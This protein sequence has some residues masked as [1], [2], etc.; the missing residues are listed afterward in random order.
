MLLSVFAVVLSI[1]VAGPA[2]AGTVI[3]SDVS[4]PNVAGNSVVYYIEPDRV[5][6]EYPGHIVIFRADQD[7]EYMLAPAEKKFRRMTPETMKQSAAAA[8]KMF[9]LLR[10]MP[11]EQRAQF[12]KRMPPEQRAQFERIMTPERLAQA[13]K[14]MAGQAPKSE[15]HKTGGT[16]SFGKWTCER[17]E[18]VRN[19]QP[20]SSLCVAH[21]SDL[22]LTEE[23]LGGLQRA[24]TFIGQMAGGVADPM[25]GFRAIEKVVG[26]AA[27]P[28]HMEIPGVEMQTTVKTVEKKPLDAGLFEVPADYREE[29]MSAPR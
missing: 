13:E 16:A 29:P 4:A 14:M 20:H 18:A 19:G 7:T 17:V 21:I 1:G 27:Y 3:T 8:A 2:L 6:M 28:V 11:P 25:E 24:A 12:E 26:Y 23:D 5:R 22:G 15:F 10:S 9:E